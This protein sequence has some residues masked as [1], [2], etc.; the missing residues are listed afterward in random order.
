M[1]AVSRGENANRGAYS[2]MPFY[3]EWETKRKSG[4]GVVPSIRFQH[5]PNIVIAVKRFTGSLLPEDNKRFS[6]W[7]SVNENIHFGSL[8]IVGRLFISFALTC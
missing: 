6:N 3:S 8:Y 1:V 4:L 7:E 5:K 2:Y